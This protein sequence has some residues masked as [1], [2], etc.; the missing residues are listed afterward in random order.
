MSF[1]GRLQQIA[2]NETW[3]EFSQKIGNNTDTAGLWDD[4]HLPSGRKT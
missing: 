1:R 4:E 2:A 3:V